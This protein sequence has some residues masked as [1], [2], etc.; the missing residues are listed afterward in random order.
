MGHITINLDV[1]AAVAIHQAAWQRLGREPTVPEMWDEMV[2]FL[3][4]AGRPPEGERREKD[5]VLEF[6]V[7]VK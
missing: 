3:Q 1:N 2:L 6:E 5:K 4:R 7:L